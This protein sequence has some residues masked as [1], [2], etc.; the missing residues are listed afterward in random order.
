MGD[1]EEEADSEP[2]AALQ[3]AMVENMRLKKQLQS[4]KKGKSLFWYSQRCVADLVNSAQHMSNSQS[5][6]SENDDTVEVLER[7]PG[8]C[9]NRR[10]GFVLIEAMHLNGDD[11][12]RQHYNDI[13]VCDH[14]S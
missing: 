5:S 7:P 12:Q 2:S 11:I 13:L 14:K 9:G 1:V 3:Q 8:E 6:T 10:T 4:L